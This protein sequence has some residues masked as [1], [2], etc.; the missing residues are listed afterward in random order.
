VLG[1]WSRGFSLLK[2]TNLVRDCEVGMELK[3]APGLRCLPLPLRHDSGETFGFRF[4]GAPDLFGAACS[5]AYAADLGSW[6]ASLA[7]SLAD[8]D[9]LAL[10][11]NHDVSLE[12]A[13][14][15]SPT[16]IARVIGD[17]GHLSNEQAAALLREVLHHCQPGRLA[18]LVQLHLSRDCNRT[19][20]AQQAARTALGELAG[21]VA[22]HTTEQDH[23]TP[24][25]VLGGAAAAPRQ[26]RRSSGTRSANPPAAQ[27][28][29]PGLDEPETN[30]PPSSIV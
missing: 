11:F 15:R 10:E 24:P 21:E 26:R 25:I 14:G 19:L 30:D 8:V 27:S 9:L 16:L 5:I 4:E 29:L 17:E 1:N 18:H 2:V 20:L 13:S 22:I 23:I 12:C 7:A 3:L 6:D 28:W